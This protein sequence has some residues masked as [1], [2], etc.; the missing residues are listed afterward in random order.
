MSL[1]P[2]INGPIANVSKFGENAFRQG[3]QRCPET[4]WQISHLLEAIKLLTEGAARLE[5]L[6]GLT[7]FA[8]LS[9]TVTSGEIG[10]TRPAPKEQPPRKLSGKRTL[11][12][13]IHLERGAEGTCSRM[14]PPTG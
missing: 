14:C 12:T 13:S 2:L 1:T 3:C 11:V 5:R 6:G 10:R 7:F 8:Y 4:V 9:T